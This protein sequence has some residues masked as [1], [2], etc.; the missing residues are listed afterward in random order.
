MAR[1]TYSIS[2]DYS[3][4]LHLELHGKAGH[5]AYVKIVTS[6]KSKYDAKAAAEKAAEKLRKQGLKI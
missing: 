5:R 2:R 4:S 3:R 6:P 1:E